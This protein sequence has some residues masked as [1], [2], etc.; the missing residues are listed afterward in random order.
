VKKSSSLRTIFITFIISSILYISIYIYYCYPLMHTELSG[1]LNDINEII[2]KHSIMPFDAKNAEFN[3]VNSYIHSID[4]KYA[5]Y[6]EPTEY[7][8]YKEETKGNFTGI[9]ISVASQPEIITDGIYIRRVYGNS[10]AEKAG[11]LAGDIIIKAGELIFNGALYNDAMNMMLGIE[12]TELDISVR[13]NG[14]I[15]DFIVKRERFKQRVVDYKIIDGNIGFI[16]IHEF[17]TNAYPEFSEALGKILETPDLKGIIFDVRNNPGGELH[18]V[19]N[20]VDLLVPK[21]EEI[22]ILQYKDN[23][24]V[25]YSELEPRI[26][27]LPMT[28]LINQSS[29]S[30]SEL[31]ASSL[32]DILNIKLIGFTTYGKGVGQTSYDLPGGAGMK[33]TTFEYLTK[34][35]NVYD[36][37]GLIPDYE[38]DLVA[39][40]LQNFYALSDEED[41]QLQMAVKILKNDLI[42]TESE[43]VLL[44]NE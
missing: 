36:S 35:R 14:E 16:R 43:Q 8:E 37:I 42:S 11:I 23:S 20:I 44:Y 3:A 25:Y 30:A 2:E 17:S 21:G 27:D 22:V 31:F 40:K 28:V 15:L 7:I 33:I 10:P 5:F 38:V 39:E 41:D 13:R 29:A 24:V 4:D 12:D 18:S 34:S 6:Y 1:K 19:T 32:R 26:K 9:G